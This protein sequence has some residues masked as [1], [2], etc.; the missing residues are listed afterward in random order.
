VQGKV[1]NVKMVCGICKS[2]TA[3]KP[4]SRWGLVADRNISNDKVFFNP[5]T[6]IIKIPP[7]IKI[8]CMSYS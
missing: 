6:F 1:S 5:Y 4:Q 8:I 2:I 3:S 7:I